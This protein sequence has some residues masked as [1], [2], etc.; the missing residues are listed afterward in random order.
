[1]KK[2]RVTWSKS[3]WATGEL[4]VEAHN[5]GEAGDIV[6]EKIG[7][8]AGKMEYNPREDEIMSVDEVSDE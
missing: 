8:L 3:Y 1:M 2:Y 5:E 6:L 7:D 4:F